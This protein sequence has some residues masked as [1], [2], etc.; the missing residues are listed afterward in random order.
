MKVTLHRGT[1]EIG[2][3]CVELSAS[4]SRIVIDV[5]MPLV[6]PDGSEFNFRNYDGLSGP[7][8]YD[9]GL[10][11]NVD[12]LYE[13]QDP[14]V[15]ALLIS[16]AHPDHYGFLKYVH[17]EVPVHL[18]EGTQKLLKISELFLPNVTAVSDPNFIQPET[19]FKCGAFT[20]I[21]HL[22]DHSAFD[23]MAFSAICGD[24]RILY[25]GDFRSHGRTG[26]TFKLLWR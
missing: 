22:V 7:E 14:T 18:S 21:P 26:Q 9:R 11:P 10:L 4:D 12:G 17:P 19:P 20:V 15:A 2:G 13:W 24:K 23:A 1:H 5:G 6:N 16:H 25:T 3:S 8:L